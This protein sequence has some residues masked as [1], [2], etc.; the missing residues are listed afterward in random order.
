M[1]E[2][3]RL[4]F[5]NYNYLEKWRLDNPTIAFYENAS[6]ELVSY[7]LVTYIDC[8]DVENSEVM[9]QHRLMELENYYVEMPDQ[10]KGLK[11]ILQQLFNNSREAS[12]LDKNTSAIYLLNFNDLKEVEHYRNLIY[13][14]EESP[15]YFK[16][17]ILPYTDNQVEELL[18][19]VHDYKNKRIVEILTD[20]ANDED[21]YYN[22]L[23]HKDSNRVYEL[24]IRLFSKIP[25]LQYM[26]KAEAI[27]MTLEKNIEYKIQDELTSYHSLIMK[28]EEINLEQ[29]IDLEANYMITDEELEN[30]FLMR[31]G[32]KM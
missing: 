14:I 27:P 20:L 11:Q 28:S 6:K 3:I 21:E 30:R 13:S 16:R 9:L 5:Q 1:E 19:I 23:D 31:L 8:R 22:L 7:F 4:I 26:F 24:V 17:Y 15:N 32:G 18:K 2:V 25:F 29:L 10:E 12:Q